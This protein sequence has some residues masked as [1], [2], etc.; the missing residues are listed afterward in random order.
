[1]FGVSMLTNLIGRRRQKTTFEPA[2]FKF[3]KVN[4][5]TPIPV[6][7]GEQL[8]Q[9]L[10][11]EMGNFRT[12]E[13]VRRPKGKKGPVYVWHTYT[14]DMAAMVCLGPVDKLVWLRFGQSDKAVNYKRSGVALTLPDLADWVKEPILDAGEIPPAETT[15]PSPKWDVGDDW[16]K[17]IRQGTF[18]WG[19]QTQT[20]D[21]L[22]DAMHT[23]ETPAYRNICYFAHR[24]D[25]SAQTTPGPITMVVQKYPQLLYGV[26]HVIG[27]HANP[28]EIIYDVVTNERLIGLDVTKVDTSGITTVAQTIG[29]EGLGCSLTLREGAANLLDAIKLLLD[30]IGGYSELTSD[31]KYSMGIKREEAASD[32]IPNSRI[33]AGSVQISRPTY[34]KTY[35]SLIIEYDSA[36]KRY[37]RVAYYLDDPAAYELAGTER[38]QRIQFGLSTDLDTIKK[39]APRVLFEISCPRGILRLKTDKL[40][41][42]KGQVVTVQYTTMNINRNFR[43][44]ELKHEEDVLDLQLVE[45]IY[46]TGVAD[47]VAPEIPKYADVFVTDYVPVE[48]WEGYLRGIQLAIEKSDINPQLASIAP[49]VYYNDILLS[50]QQYLPPNVLGTLKFDLPQSPGLVDTTTTITVL[51]NIDT[52]EITSTNK[53]GWYSGSLALWIDG[54]II[55]CKDVTVFSDRYEFTNLIRGREWTTNSAHSTGKSVQFLGIFAEATLLDP[56]SLAPCTLDI[57]ILPYHMYSGFPQPDNDHIDTKTLNYQ[58]LKYSPLPVQNIQIGSQG[59]DNTFSGSPDLTFNWR[60]TTRIGGAGLD[61]S[62]TRACNENEREITQFKIEALTV[63]NVVKNTYYT[64]DPTW[65]YLNADRVTDGLTVSFKL[66]IYQVGTYTGPYVEFLAQKI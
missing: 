66:R 20:V 55:Y 30:F 43:I 25:L 28:V 21:S 58:A 16:I 49:G 48:V 46:S 5:G 1:M 44:I 37:D 54:E 7:W 8:V 18:Y 47:F 63:G 60:E 14:I 9:P 40:D 50:E 11:L 52:I 34:M 26:S 19:T 33:V 59:Y 61:F 57:E 42:R 62:C 4:Y 38:I 12:E 3:S 23:A 2:E 36:E 53:W 31:G 64:T 17:G 24:Q 35:T 22:L 29:S 13:H 45:E 27:R 10:Y 56:E 65:T 51:R 39:I 15:K 32:T 6:I 41:V